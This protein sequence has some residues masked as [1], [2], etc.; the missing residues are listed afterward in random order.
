LRQQHPGKRVV[1]AEF[2][3]PSGGYNRA[4]AEPGRLEQ[5]TVLRQFV[6]RADALGIDYNI[7]EAFDQ[8]WKVSEGSVGRY[9]GIFDAS[10]QAKFSWTGP[11]GNPDYWKIAAIAVAIGFLV[12]LPIL[13]IAGATWPQA[14]LMAFA[15]HAVG[16]WAAT[17]FEFWTDHY[18]VF[19]AALA[20]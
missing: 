19:G 8:P 15:A 20:L 17:V 14:V 5:A 7:I 18:F 9:L 1:I 12:S 10:R 6:T 16:A 3:W 11:I 4:D 2:G 13:A